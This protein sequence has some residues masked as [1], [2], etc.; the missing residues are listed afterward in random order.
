MDRSTAIEEVRQIFGD[1]RVEEYNRVTDYGYSNVSQAADRAGL[2]ADVCG[3]A[4]GIA[5][6]ARLAVEQ[7]ARDA[8]LSPED[9]KQQI[10]ALQSQAESRLI[11]A[12]GSPP[13][14]AIRRALVMTLENTVATCHP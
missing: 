8:S 13:N 14:P 2:P 5:Y 9:R 3:L 10:Q 12:L 1:D 7:V 4:G 6:E 11:A